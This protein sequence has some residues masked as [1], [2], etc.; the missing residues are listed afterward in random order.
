MRSA[1]LIDVRPRPKRRTS[2]CDLPARVQWVEPER[3][4]RDTVSHGHDA[5]TPQC[6]ILAWLNQTNQRDSA[7]GR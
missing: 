3:M 2:R 4:N 1:T 6:G 5:G 7:H